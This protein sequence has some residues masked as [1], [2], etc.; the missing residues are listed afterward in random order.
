MRLFHFSDNL[1]IDIFIPRPVRISV[2]RPLGMAWLNGPL[3]WAIDEKHQ[4]MYLFP[5][6]CPR[7]LLWTTPGTTTGDHDYWWQGSRSKVLAYIEEAWLGR[8]QGETI[9]RY[10]MP[11]ST[12]EDL[13]DAGM[14]VS[15]VA[16]KPSRL[17]ALSNLPKEHQAYDVELRV[18]E[19]LL[20]LKEVWNSSLHASG[21]RLR[22]A[23]RWGEP[24]WTHSKR[25]RVVPITTSD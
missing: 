12:F 16:V 4:P 10:E 24:S 22:N 13:D 7:V 23:Q 20:P 6:E 14:W 21:I 25:V 9:Y 11:S 15:K 8:V 17:E 3:V 5:R 1:D 19:N 2:E 18:L